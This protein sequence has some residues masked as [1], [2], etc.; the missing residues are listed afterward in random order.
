MKQIRKINMLRFYFKLMT[1]K[2]INA[3][4]FKSL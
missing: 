4:A 3:N 1:L 2:L